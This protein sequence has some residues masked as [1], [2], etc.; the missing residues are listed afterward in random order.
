MA[1]RE[2]QIGL[3]FE[4]EAAQQPQQAQPLVEGL[5]LWSSSERL[6]EL[7]GANL[8]TEKEAG[9]RSASL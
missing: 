1:E 4:S 9:A 8:V 5:E 2:A 6:A 3:L 7:A